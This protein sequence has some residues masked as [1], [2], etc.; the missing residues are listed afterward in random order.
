M[1][2]RHQINAENL[3]SDHSL[4]IT[5]QEIPFVVKKLNKIMISRDEYDTY[6][7]HY[8]DDHYVGFLICMFRF[9]RHYLVQL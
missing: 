6:V 7:S 2:V 3:H 4:L 5:K 9:V 8:Y 1:I